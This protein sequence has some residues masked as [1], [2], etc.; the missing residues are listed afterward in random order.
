[1][2][3]YIYF[4]LLLFI[5]LRPL[6]NNNNKN[7][8]PYIYIKWNKYNLLRIKP[9]FR[10]KLVYLSRYIVLYYINLLL[11]LFFFKD[12]LTAKVLTTKFM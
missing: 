3:T 1:M 7:I 4:K 9:F 8:I 6:N 12:L 5:F 10:R 2:Y 11:L